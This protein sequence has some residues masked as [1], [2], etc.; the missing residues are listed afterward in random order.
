MTI[1]VSATK[2]NLE[3]ERDLFV[4]SVTHLLVEDDTGEPQVAEVE[5]I[6]DVENRDK[7]DVYFKYRFIKFRLNFETR[8]FEP[9]VFDC[10]Q[11]PE[12]LKSKYGKGIQSEAA[13]KQKQE[14]FGKCLIE[15]P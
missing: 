11:A 1:K 4:G 14:L 7:L 8:R 12:F 5:I 15:V 3:K 13:V 9:V 10:I 6:Y 2:L